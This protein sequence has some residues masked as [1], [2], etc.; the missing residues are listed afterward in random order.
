MAARNI[1]EVARDGALSLA[2]GRLLDRQDQVRQ[3]PARRRGR[4]AAGGGGREPGRRAGRRR[5]EGRAVRALHL[6]GGLRERAAVL[7]LA[8]PAVGQGDHPGRGDGRHRP[9]HR[10]GHGQVVRARQGPGSRRG[11]R[12][13]HAVGHHRH[14]RRRDRQARPR[15]GRDRAAAGQRGDRLRRDLRL[16]LL[17]RDHRLRQPAAQVHGPHHPRRRD[18]GRDRDAG[19]REGAGQRPGRSRAL[20]GGPHLRTHGRSAAHRGRHRER[21]PGHHHHHRACEARRPLRRGQPHARAAPRRHRAGRG[22]ARRGGGE[23]RCWARRSTRSRAWNSP[24]T[25]ATSC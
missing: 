4:L 7:Q 12:R 6:R 23:R 9:G 14:G 1:Q 2:G 3:V 10:G 20:A 17:R 21:R 11:G 15:R 16:R 22:P 18:R 5:R 25:S 24:C 13:P 19:R 8:G